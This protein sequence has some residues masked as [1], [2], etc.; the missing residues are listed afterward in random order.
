ML[1]IVTEAEVGAGAEPS[2]KLCQRSAMV[3]GHHY[4]ETYNS[5]LRIKDSLRRLLKCYHRQWSSLAL[6]YQLSSHLSSAAPLSQG[7]YSCSAGR[8]AYIDRPPHIFRRSM[9]AYATRPFFRRCPRHLQSSTTL[10]L[11]RPLSGRL[12]HASGTAAGAQ[13][14][15]LD[16][17]SLATRFP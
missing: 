15:L 6:V 9:D 7:F 10:S 14:R 5:S 2:Q 17:H 12:H 4:Q 3:A 8:G 16:H 1:R 11:N 13:C